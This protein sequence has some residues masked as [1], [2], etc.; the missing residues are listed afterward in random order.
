[1]SE[2]TS[3]HKSKQ[4]RR[5]HY[6]AEWAE[7]RG[8]TQADLA[9]ELGADKSVVSRWFNGTSPSQE[10]QER[11]AELIWKQAL[12]YVE[13]VRNEEGTLTK[14]VHKPVAWAQQYLFERMEGKAAIAA[15]DASVGMRAADKVRA[16]AKDRLNRI[17][18]T[19]TAPKASRP[20]VHKPA[21]NE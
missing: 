15:P 2:I 12:G 10:W 3:I 6:I 14:V 21:S 13:E 18:E 4:P 16:L 7:L 11:L 19:V 8:L 20:P 9:R 1:M 17:A 5:P